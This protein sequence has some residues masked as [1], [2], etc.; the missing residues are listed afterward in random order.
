MP[1]RDS[2][3]ATGGQIGV[4]GP[5][6]QTFDEP[7]RAARP[8]SPHPVA[9]VRAHS[10][11]AA[12]DRMNETDLIEQVYSTVADS[13]R[14]PEVIVRIADYLGAVGGMLLCMTPEG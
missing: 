11:C 9:R 5:D 6:A 13:G 10:R 1:G 3:R 2:R 14:W 12:R 8:N 7:G 4:A